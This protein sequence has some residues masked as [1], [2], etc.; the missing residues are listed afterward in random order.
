MNPSVLAYGALAM[1]IACEVAGTSFLQRS[2]QFSKLTPSILSALFYAASFY[3][4]A[5]ALRMVPLGVAY[6][7][8]GGLGIV[9]TAVVSV[10]VFRQTLDAAAMI[11]IG[12]IVGGVVIVNA[13]SG[14][15]SH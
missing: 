6:A 9:L 2:E 11:G 14:S 10:V 8:W 3:L 15:A 13:F 4:L 5:Q 7:I 1:A 12:M